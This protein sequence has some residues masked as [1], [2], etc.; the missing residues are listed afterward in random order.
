[1]SRAYPL[2]EITKL[3]HASFRGLD[4]ARTVHLAARTTK[5]NPS[6]L[7]NLPQE[8]LRGVSSLEVDLQD[9]GNCPLRAALTDPFWARWKGCISG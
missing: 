5:I 7:K 9:L 8:A 6:G 4:K 3:K 1:M 2:T